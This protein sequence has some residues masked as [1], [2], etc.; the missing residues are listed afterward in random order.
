MITASVAAGRLEQYL[1]EVPEEFHGLV[2]DIAADITAQATVF[3]VDVHAYF[4]RAPQGCSRKDFAFWVQHYVPP[5]YRPGL[6][7]LLDGRT[8]NW[9][10]LSQRA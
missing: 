5:Q 2:R 8:P 1:R 7:Q 10:L 3:A 6:F 9:V 4:A